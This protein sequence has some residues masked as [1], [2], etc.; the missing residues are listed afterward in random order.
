MKPIQGI[1]SALF[2]IV[3][4]GVLDNLKLRAAAAYVAG[5]RKTRQG[6]VALLG[7]LLLLLLMMSG[8]LLIHVALFMWLPWSVP[9]KALSLLVLGAIYLGGGLAVVLYISSD[10]TW[11]KF[12][13]VNRI[14]ASLP[15][16][17]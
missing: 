13:K 17:K 6:F 9:A 10:R 16:G 3:V 7:S 4:G 12:T 14:L 1:I 11:M 5:V 15:P 8:F 2:G